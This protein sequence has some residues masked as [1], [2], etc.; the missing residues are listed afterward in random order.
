MATNIIH[1]AGEELKDRLEFGDF[2]LGKDGELK[3]KPISGRDLVI[4]QG[5]EYDKRQLGRNMPTSI[6]AQSSDSQLQALADK[7]SVLG[8]AIKPPIEAERVEDEE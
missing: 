5:T 8:N 2:V 6:K 7:I 3:R 1:K 4:I